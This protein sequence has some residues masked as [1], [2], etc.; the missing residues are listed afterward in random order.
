[1]QWSDVH[2]DSCALALG[3]RE[4]TDEAV[5]AGRYDPEYRVAHGYRSV[6]VADDGMPMDLAVAAGRQALS[7]SRLRPDDVRL[8][9]HTYCNPQGPAHIQPAPYVQGKVLPPGTCALEV[10]QACN[11]GL[12]AMEMGAAYLGVAPAGSAV[13]LTTSDKHPPEEGDRYRTDPGNLPG[14]GGT[15]LLL[16][17][18][19]GVARLLSTVMVSDGTFSVPDIAR[20]DDYATR[21]EFLEE[22]RRRL[23]PVLK[24]MAELQRECAHQALADA[25]TKPAEVKRWVFAHTGN[26]LAHHAFQEEFGITDAMTTWEWGRTVGHFGAGDQIA[27]LT[28]LLESGAVSAG[29][30]VALFGNG[31]GFSYGCVVLEITTRPEWS[32]D[33][34]Y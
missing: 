32:V 7:R 22:Q 16:T 5:A 21:K 20:P 23:L 19:G 14:D 11:G 30:R 17:R 10:N 18:G 25:D 27:G 2:I 9:V 13:L 8:L 28:H 15:G 26:F 12:A 1:M 34:D 3:R 6:S 31:V 33:R 4:D 29:D 24:A